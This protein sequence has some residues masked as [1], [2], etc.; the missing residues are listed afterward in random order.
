L[1]A[2]M[3][4]VVVPVA[5]QQGYRE[6]SEAAAAMVAAAALAPEEV[7]TE[8]EVMVAEASAGAEPAVGARD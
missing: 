6:G 1:A 5:D 7:A 8:A 4:M 3:A 2:A